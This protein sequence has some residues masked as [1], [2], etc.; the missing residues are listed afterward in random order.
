MKKPLISIVIPVYNVELYIE[1]CLTSVINQTYNNLEIII[2]DDGSLDHSI[3]IAQKVVS[4]DERV[5]FLTKENGGLSDARNAGIL[6][7]QGEYIYFLDSDDI[8]TVD[9][10]DSLY[11]A[12]YISKTD[13]AI[14]NH[15]EIVDK[16]VLERVDNVSSIKYDVLSSVQAFKNIYSKNLHTCILHTVAW[17]KLYKTNLIKEI[18]FPYGK[19]HEDEF[20]T[21]KLYMKIENVV[22]ID[23]ITYGYRIRDNSI[24]TSQF[25]LNSLHTIEAY[26]ERIKLL[27]KYNEELLLLTQYQ[28]VYQ[29]ERYRK[30][31]IQYQYQ[32]QANELRTKQYHMFR[33]IFLKL[34]IIQKMKLI[35]HM[36]F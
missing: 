33:K 16:D 24:M 6:K 19:T 9:C 35:K 36:F 27:E 32:Q 26:E 15:K 1:D 5:V 25:N 10:I 17:N 28:Y 12:L 20:T 22:Y 31:L 21:Y 30:K 7:S 34:N 29:L 3:N 4:N 13:M 14:G 23:K 11:E 8:L 18:L 2:V